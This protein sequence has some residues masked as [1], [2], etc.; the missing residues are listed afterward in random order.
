MRAEA[1]DLPPV[2]DEASPLDLEGE[3]LHISD[4]MTPIDVPSRI[5]K[6]NYMD[7]FG[8]KLPEN[9]DPN[10]FEDGELELEQ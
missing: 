2:T 4:G 8:G 5:T 6:E 9:I 10:L 1:F 7:L 3:E